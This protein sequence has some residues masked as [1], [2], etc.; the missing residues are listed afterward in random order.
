FSPYESAGKALEG[1]GSM[2]LDRVNRIVYACRSQRTDAD[3]LEEFCERFDY[4]AVL[5]DAVDRH[6][7]PIYHTNVMMTLGTAFAVV[8]IDSVRDRTQKDE[9]LASLRQTGHEV[10]AI[11]YRQ[12]EQFAGNMLELRAGEEILVAMSQRARDSLDD[13]QLAV[14]ERHA[15][16]VS[17]P[18]NTLEDYG[19]G[20]VRCMLA[21]I[22]LPLEDSN[23]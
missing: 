19:G 17:S 22:F 23:D 6:G 13:E 9:L 2:I 15:K 3:V 14:L 7:M 21:E 18:I 10:I 16:I 1:T 8:C 12:V 4:R 20:S 11:S 5:F